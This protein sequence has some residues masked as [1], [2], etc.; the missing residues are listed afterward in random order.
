MTIY[1]IIKDGEA[2][3]GFNERDKRDLC[4]EYLNFLEGD[5]YTAGEEEVEDDE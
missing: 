2:L 3:A 5:I 1:T 4:L